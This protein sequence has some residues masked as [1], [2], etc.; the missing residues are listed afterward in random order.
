M[1][2]SPVPG[3]FPTVA[4]VG[5][6]QLARMMQSAAVELGVR[7]RLLTVD[8]D[9]SAA[10][11]I[12]DMRVGHHTDL[13]A[14][15][16]LVDGAD[17]VTFDHEHVPTSHLQALAADGVVVRPGPEA[18]VHAQDKLVMRSRLTEMG[19]PCPRWSAVHSAAEL[20]AFGDDVGWP[21]VLKTPRGG[22]DG[23]G[24]RVV[25]SVEEAADWL[26][27]AAGGALLAEERVDYCRELATLV[28]RSPTGQCAAWPVVE[29]VQTDGVCD[30]VIAP[31]PDLEETVGAAATATALRVAGK[32]GVT[33]VLAVESFETRDGRVLV[34]ELAMRPHNSGHWTI[35]GSVTSQFEQHLRAVLDLPLGTTNVRSRWTVMVNVLGGE[36]EDLYRSYLHVMA[37]D[38]AVKVHLYGKAVRPGRKVGHVTAYGDSLDDVRARARHAADFIRGVIDE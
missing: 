36:Y 23:K 18:L 37:R 4:V 12:P 33:G 8:P 32:L 24:V 26:S 34:N 25:G 29:S 10:Q 9:D 17:V 11:V 22:Y 28:A 6:G 15:R 38:P 2:A 31:A 20:K 27:R 3:G 35:D 14:L 13:D 19:V 21:V 16:S 7:L 1:A 5:G 30:E